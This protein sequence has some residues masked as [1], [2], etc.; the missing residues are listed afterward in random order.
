MFPPKKILFPVDFS[1]RCVATARMVENFAERFRSEVTMLHAVEPITIGMEYA[2][3]AITPAEQ[4]L[5]TFLVDELK[6][7]PV[8]RVLLQGDAALETIQYAHKGKFDLIMLPTHGY[9]RFRRFLLGSV[10]AKILHDAMC[11][12]W[13]SVHI[14]EIA[15]PEKITFKNVVC[16]IDLGPQSC[17]ALTWAAKFAEQAGADLTI[18]H[19]IPAAQDIPDFYTD[20]DF[21]SD[22]LH[23][24]R[25][26]IAHLQESLGTQA[27]VVIIPDDVPEGVRGCVEGSNADLLVI[28]RSIQ[29]GILGR[30]R[31]NAYAIIRQSPCPV[32]SV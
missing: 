25:E 30:L 26:N 13:T 8:K 27:K 10:A 31:T 32:V 12:V 16:A 28:G 2:Y 21:K 17:R 11:P 5:Q 7:L 19:A 24:A 6:H 4:M 14:E 3:D 9:G 23:N 29:N 15:P 22:L 20:E 18:A 1:D